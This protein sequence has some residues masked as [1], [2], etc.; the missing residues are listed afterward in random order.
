MTQ[1][2][3]E[4]VA[5]G[6]DY[7]PPY[8]CEAGCT[9]NV[10]VSVP[11]APL[12]SL[13]T[14]RD[15][16]SYDPDLSSVGIER[17]ALSP[18]AACVSRVLVHGWSL[19]AESDVW[20]CAPDPRLVGFDR[21]SLGPGE[22][23]VSRIFSDN[24]SFDLWQ[25]LVVVLSNEGPHWTCECEPLHLLG[26]GSS[27][28]EALRSFMHDFADTYN[29]LIGEPDERLSADAQALK[30]DLARLVLRA[31]VLSRTESAFPGT[32]YLRVG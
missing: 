1:W 18:G 16:W 19:P 28:D 26:Y 5:A 30:R 32:S 17:L 23:R 21:P 11:M 29:G 7:G 10:Q 9:T 22:V 13:S 2:D 6:E 14:E 12:D 25:N 27:A 20:S 15:V 31:V 24:R 4:C 8:A 3:E